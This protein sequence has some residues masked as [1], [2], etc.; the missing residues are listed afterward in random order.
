MSSND[1]Y[2]A[3]VDEILNEFPEAK[4]NSL[5]LKTIQQILSSKLATPEVFDDL[6]ELV[7]DI[8]GDFPN[9]IVSDDIFGHKFSN[10]VHD[11]FLNIILATESF[12]EDGTVHYDS[13]DYVWS[14][15]H[16]KPFIYCNGVFRDIKYRTNEISNIIKEQ[17]GYLIAEFVVL[18]ISPKLP[19]ENLYSLYRLNPPD[20]V[21]ITPFL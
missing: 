19:P 14:N 21:Q 18:D 5:S 11:R 6:I 3:M 9:V 8:V 1:N 4:H 7:I 2:Q 17:G 16:G 12:N 13:L 10:Y 20:E 15:I